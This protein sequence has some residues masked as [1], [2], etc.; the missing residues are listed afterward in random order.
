MTREEE[1]IRIITKERDE[2]I[3]GSWTPHRKRIHEAFTLAIETL[4]ADTV[5]VV[6]CK[7]CK[8]YKP[9]D[10]S[11]KFDCPQGLYAVFENDYCSHGERSE[12]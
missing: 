3:F 7:D 6:R 11:K 12:E 10:K 9:F 8:H 4:Q 1:A 2:D 5:E